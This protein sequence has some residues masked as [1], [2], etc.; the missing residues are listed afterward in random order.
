M[1]KKGVLVTYKSKIKAKVLRLFK[2]GPVLKIAC[3][4]SAC[5]TGSDHATIVNCV[6]QTDLRLHRLD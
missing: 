6:E 4:Y 1:Y 5:C 2:V 3:K